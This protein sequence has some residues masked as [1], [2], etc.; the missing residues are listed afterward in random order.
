MATARPDG[1][2]RAVPGRR[3][4]GVI[5]GVTNDVY[6]LFTRRTPYV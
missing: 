5:Y 4:A 3:I 2:G 6:P 1:A